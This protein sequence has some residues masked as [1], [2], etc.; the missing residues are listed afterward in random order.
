MA[1]RKGNHDSAV[2]EIGQTDQWDRSES[3]NR[4]PLDTANSSL[5]M[6]QKQSS[7]KDTACSTNCA[8]HLHSS[9]SPKW[10]RDL[11]AK[12]KTSRCSILVV[13]RRKPR[14]LKQWLLRSEGRCLG[15]R[16]GVDSTLLKLEVCSVEA[17]LSH[18]LGES[19]YWSHIVCMKDCCQQIQDSNSRK[20]K[21]ESQVKAMAGNGNRFLTEVMH[22]LQ[23]GNRDPHN[24]AL[25]MSH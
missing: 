8:G 7:G 20:T 21:P 10:T 12:C 22:R 18:R 11:R 5:T 3:K 16:N 24:M 17:P 13:N 23:T 9:P 1:Y 14:G 4:P 6:G 19:V 25:G 15:E 2:M